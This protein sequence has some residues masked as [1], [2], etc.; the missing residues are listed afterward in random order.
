[1]NVIEK[2]SVAYAK[3]LKKWLIDETFTSEKAIINYDKMRNDLDGEFKL[4]CNFFDVA[5]DPE[6]LNQ[7]SK[8][9]SK[10]KLKA[11]TKHDDRVVNLKS[12]YAEKRQEFTNNHS[13]II[14][15]IIFDVEPEL[16][17]YF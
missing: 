16:S 15:K 7:V 8:E 9:V 6:K 12:G 5:F 13:E 4:I 1:M 17:R 14:K 3:H 2:W 11:K 10:D